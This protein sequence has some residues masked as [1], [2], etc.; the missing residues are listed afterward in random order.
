MKRLEKI[1]NK[2][3]QTG[4]QMNRYKESDCLCQWATHFEI[5]YI[6]KNQELRKLYAF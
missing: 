2:V 5:D 3:W 4:R 6:M 1:A